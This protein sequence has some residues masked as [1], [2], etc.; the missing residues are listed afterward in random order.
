MAINPNIALQGQP[1]NMQQAIMGGLETGERIRNMGIRDAL[2]RQQQQAGQQQLQQGRTQAAMQQGALA[3][4]VFSQLSQVPLSERA[5]VLAR[6]GPRLSQM[7]IDP[8]QI[9][10]SDDGIQRGLQATQMFAPQGGGEA[11][12]LKAGETRFGPQG[13]VIASGGE[14][15]DENLEQVRKEVRTE[16]RGTVGD[17]RKTAGNLRS[18]YEKLTNLGEEMRKGNRTA[19]SQGLVALVKLGDPTSV[20][21]EAEMEAA[22][23]K[24][25]P[26]AA[27]T[28]LLQS[29]GTAE[30]VVSAVASKI[31]PLS[32]ENINV[33][34]VL[35]TANA[36]M[37]PN[38]QEVRRGFEIAQGRARENLESEGIRSIFGKR[39]E[40]L[41]G[42]L[43]AIE[44]R[45]TET[46]ARAQQPQGGGQQPP[47]GGQAQPGQGAQQPGTQQPS[48]EVLMEHPRFGAVTEADIQQTMQETGMTRQQVFQRLMEQA[49]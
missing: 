39:T 18:N 20:V 22:L 15:P 38:I 34:D 27:I 46:R 9:D 49:Q 45:I 23:N 10:I 32:P 41:F 6:M 28:N 21:R 37:V 36:M 2:L 42:E 47:P 8:R 24:E 35:A 13:R 5:G 43:G 7:G 3:N 4:Q 44:S 48:G 29:K 30:G 33:D 11:F 14:V 1:V 25:N 26:V 40:D 31:D 19:V 16:L 17:L 12:T